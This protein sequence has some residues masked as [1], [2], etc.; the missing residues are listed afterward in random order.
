MTTPP[1][2]TV[3]W[4]Q[5]GSHEPEQVKA[6]YQELFGWNFAQDPNQDGNYDLVTYPGSEMPVGGIAHLDDA[7]GNHAIFYVLVQD[8][9]EILAAAEKAG[10]KVFVQPVTAANGLVFSELLD[11]SG[12]RFGIF[13]P[14]PA[15]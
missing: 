10:G 11:T 3:A 14:P 2:N 13:S 8:V 12:N 7:S 15:N 6:F 4:F 1:F 5:V 9:P